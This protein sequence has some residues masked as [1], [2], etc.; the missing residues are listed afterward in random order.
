M[1]FLLPSPPAQTG[2]LSLASSLGREPRIIY[3]LLS[4]AGA[5][6]E[7]P[8]GKWD[9]ISNQRDAGRSLEKTGHEPEWS[10]AIFV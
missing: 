10:S 9:H 6:S 8:S 4:F 5:L 3:R 7:D 1:W 2:F